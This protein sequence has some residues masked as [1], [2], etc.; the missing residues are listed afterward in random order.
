MGKNLELT[1]ACNY[2]ASPISDWR[3]RLQIGKEYILSSALGKHK[4][5]VNLYIFS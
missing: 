5:L 4:Y 1:V 3:N 2:V